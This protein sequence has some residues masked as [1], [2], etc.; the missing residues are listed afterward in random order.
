MA[1]HPGG[2]F[3]LAAPHRRARPARAPQPSGHR[4]LS[5]PAGSDPQPEPAVLLVD[6][7]VL[8]RP[9]TGAVQGD[10]AAG[11]APGTVERHAYRHSSYE[12]MLL[13]LTPEHR[14][15]AGVRQR[16]A[17]QV[18]AVPAAV[19]VRAWREDRGSRRE[20]MVELLHRA[21]EAGVRCAVLAN[22]A[23]SVRRDLAFHG[24]GVEVAYC[25]AELGVTVPSSLAFRAVAEHMGLPPGRVHYAAAGPVAVA[26]A[27]EAGMKAALTSGPAQLA[28]FLAELGVQAQARTSTAA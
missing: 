19:A 25:S 13:G 22:G 15:A 18:G 27:R 17:A 1:F 11:L 26:G 20:R 3:F 9:G 7:A 5:L 10:R 14:W 8:V 16:L 23:A 24:I 21:R 2:S 4:A 12:A 28:V 6:L